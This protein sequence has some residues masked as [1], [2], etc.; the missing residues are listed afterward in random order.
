MTTSLT[1][2]S[3]RLGSFSEDER[4]TK[5]LNCVRVGSWLLEMVDDDSFRT[6]MSFLNGA[7]LLKLA[8]ISK[9]LRQKMTISIVVYAGISSG[10]LSEQIIRLLHNLL[11]RGA[12][13]VPSP[14]RLLK[15]INGKLCESC[16][17]KKMNILAIQ[18]FSMFL[19]KACLKCNTTQKPISYWGKDVACDPLVPGICDEK[20]G[21][22][23]VWQRNLSESDGE[24]CGPRVDS[25]KLSAAIVCAKEEEPLST[26]LLYRF[27]PKQKI[28]E[29]FLNAYKIAVDDAKDRNDRK[30][31]KRKTRQDTLANA[32]QERLSNS[33]RLV[34]CIKLK[35]E[36]PWVESALSN[37]ETHQYGRQPCLVFNHPFCNELL[38][39][40]VT[41][42]SKA[43]KRATIEAFAKAIKDH[44]TNA[45]VLDDH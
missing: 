40:A 41:A 2:T 43:N 21:T 26:E 14:L 37:T 34:K 29:E 31:K 7:E 8:F 38:Q 42:P 39:Q 15:L 9:T 33:R 10:G 12:I 4:P 27:I 18:H 25:S 6:V 24:L 35:L 28:P 20:K 23:R 32:Y 36:G 30:E 13:H 44:F 16:K 22:I 3:K 1:T 5:R 45:V 17:E 19:C 11:Q